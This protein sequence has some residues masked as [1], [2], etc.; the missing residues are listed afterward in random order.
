MIRVPTIDDS[1]SESDETFDLNISVTSGPTQNT[2]ASGTATIIDND[3]SNAAPTA[4]DKT[5]TIDEDTPTAL[6]VSDFG[7]N[8]AD[9][10]I[11]NSVK[12]TTL[13]D[14]GA[15]QYYNGTNWVDVTLNQV[16]TKADIDNGNFRFNPDLNEN[17]NN[18]TTFQFTVNDGTTNSAT[19]NTITYN[20]TPINDAPILDLDNDDSTTSADSK[21]Y[22]TSYALGKTGVS[23]GD[24]DVSVTDVDDTNIESATITLTNAQT[25]DLLFASDLPNGITVDN[26]SISTLIKLTGSATLSDYEKAIE[27][28]R[29]YNKDTSAS[30][31]KRTV[32]VVVNDGDINSNTV[33]TTIKVATNA[34]IIDSQ[35]SVYEGESAIFNV[36]LAKTESSATKVYLTTSGTSTST[37]DYNAQ[38]MYESSPGTWTNVLNDGGG[39]YIEI[40]ANTLSVDIKIKTIGGDAQDDGESLVLSGVA[41]TLSNPNASAS[42]IITEKPSIQVSA[43]SYVIEGN[44]A[45][46]EVSLTKTKDSNTVVDLEIS[47]DVVGADYTAFEYSTDGT[48]WTTISSNQITLAS[49]TST[50]PSM[51]VR[52]TTA[53]SDGADNL[54]SLVL[55]VTTSDSGISS[56]GNSASDSTIVIEPLALTVTEEKDDTANAST[57]VTTTLD[58]NYIYQKVSDGVNGTVIDNGDGT[59][60]YT[61][62]TDFSGSDTFTYLMINKTTGETITAVANVT[63]TAVADTPDIELNANIVI[64]ENINKDIWVNVGRQGAVGTSEDV[65]TVLPTSLTLDNGD[66]IYQNFSS[67]LSGLYDLTIDYTGDNPTVNVYVGNLSDSTITNITSKALDITS[68]SL[69]SIDMTGFDTIIISNGNN[70]KTL[71]INSM[72]LSVTIAANTEIYNL[73]IYNALTDY[74]NQDSGSVNVEL[75]KEVTLSGIPSGATLKSGDTTITVTSG[76]AT[77]TQSQLDNLQLTVST[78]DA[79]NGFTLIATATSEEQSNGSIATNTATVS[80]ISTNDTPTIEDQSMQVINGNA[81]TSGSNID[82]Y[83]STDGGNVFSWDPSKT[84]IP[85]LYADGQKVD[86]TFDNVAGTVTGTINNGST[87]IF[88]TTISM[89]DSDGTTLNYTQGS[90]LL[91]VVNMVDGDIILPGGGNNDYRIFQFTDA[92]GSANVVVDALVSAHNLIE[93]SAADLSDSDAEHTVNT[94]NYYIGVDSNNMNAGQQLIFDFN[95]VSTYDGIT[96]TS[97]EVSEINIKLFNFGSEKSGDELFITVITTAGREEILLTDDSFYTSDLEYTITSQNGDPILGVEFLAGNVSSFK[98]GIESIGSISYN[99]TFEMKYAYDITDVDGDSDSGLTTIQ[100]GTGTVNSSLDYQTDSII[101]YDSTDFVIDG[102]IGTDTLALDGGIDIDFTTYTNDINNIEK[103]DLTNSSADNDLTNIALQDVIDITDSNNL[104]SILG[105]SG[106]TVSLDNTGGTWSTDDSTDVDG[107]KTYVNSS[108]NSVSLKIDSDITV[109]GLI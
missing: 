36:S 17:G 101:K 68:G 79:S 90:E 78:T 57:S 98:L 40:P 53:S 92:D 91:G 46:F 88:T 27:A 32:T 61:P 19:P 30:T 10:D 89:A 6:T 102:G 107:L 65:S 7:Y 99:D 43:P 56:Y 5:I 86:I 93:D 81:N 13:E 51:F 41:S 96:T 95:T 16:I 25:G 52:V 109:S 42:T 73:D 104:L 39:D 50:P 103:I 4:A 14:D 58:A 9:N 84:Q 60:T 85:E 106:D 20:V 74:D 11:I 23:I 76:S 108:D 64:S 70:G 87:T 2:S 62:N 47:G 1:D 45:V 48:N 66:F 69:Q 83:Y 26:T 100:V 18:Y 80:I 97:N 77:I 31:A 49:N 28:I 71:T 29:F 21:D 38:L 34:L 94:N 37:A 82:T 3:N 55:N 33:T 8:D 54:E 63:V 75:L 72:D 24:T 12:I 22:N 44:S 59:L 15:L 35:P 67:T 105:E